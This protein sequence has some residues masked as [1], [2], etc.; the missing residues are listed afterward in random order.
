[1]STELTEL[2]KRLERINSDLE[3]FKM[4]TKTADRKDEAKNLYNTIYNATQALN[5]NISDADKA[6]VLLAL[7]ADI[8]ASK[9]KIFPGEKLKGSGLASKIQRSLGRVGLSNKTTSIKEIYTDLMELAS[10]KGRLFTLAMS[11]G[12]KLDEKPISKIS[13][14][15]GG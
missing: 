13:K 9:E 14:P 1:M 10:D 11:L 12:Y 15:S 7:K 6:G 4:E 3:G 8:I 2:V 5:G